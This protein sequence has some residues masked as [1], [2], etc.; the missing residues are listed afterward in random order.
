MDKLRAMQVFVAIAEHGSLTAAARALDSSLP[1][2]VRALAAL[3][4]HLII[5]C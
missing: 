5:L 2:T 1:A 4:V 3:E